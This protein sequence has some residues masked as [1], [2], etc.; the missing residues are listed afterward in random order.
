MDYQDSKDTFKS[1][2]NC[3]SGETGQGFGTETKLKPSDNLPSLLTVG[4]AANYLRCSP[5]TLYNYKSAGKIRGYNRGGTKKGQLLFR[6]EDLDAFI[7][8]KRR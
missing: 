2:G 4:E 6:R 1:N 7:Y 5:K 3:P 8:G